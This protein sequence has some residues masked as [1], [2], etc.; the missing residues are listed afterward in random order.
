[1]PKWYL[2]FWASRLEITLEMLDFAELETNRPHKTRMSV[3]GQGGLDFH[4]NTLASF[5]E[6]LLC[7]G[8]S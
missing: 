8:F 4:G 6:T 1:M 7:K 5:Q 3:A 2:K